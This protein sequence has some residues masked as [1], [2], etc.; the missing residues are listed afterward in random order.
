MAAKTEQSTLQR[1][2]SLHFLLKDFKGSP[3]LT[4]EEI[5][6]GLNKVS[7]LKQN[8][9]QAIQITLKSCI[10]TLKDTESRDTLKIHG[11]DLRDKHII[12]T[13]VEKSLTNVMVKDAPVEMLDSCIVTSLQPFGDVVPYSVKRGKI[14]GTDIENGTRHLQMVNV[15]CIIPN[16]FHIGRFIIRVFCDN[17]KSACDHCHSTA[18]SS[19]SCPDK[20]R[21]NLR[22]CWKCGGIDH[23]AADCPD[24]MCKKCGRSD[25]QF[26]QCP[27]TTTNLE[28][29]EH[30]DFYARN[31]LRA[32]I[33]PKDVLSNFFKVENGVVYGDETYPTVEHAYVIRSS[34]TKSSCVDP[35]PTS[36]KDF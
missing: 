32:F 18:H 28:K 21:R 15:K 29:E 5:I 8:C 4:N 7:G 31:A 26:D 12:L 11:L 24:Q 13:D 6:E 30:G 9:I 35:I 25:H 3:R 19:F 10:I 22:R 27:E 34:A 14:R 20:P 36:L 23:M 16:Q 2:N 33:G 1:P 17:G